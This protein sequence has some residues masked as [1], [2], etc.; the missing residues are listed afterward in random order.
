MSINEP[1][2]ELRPPLAGRNDNP[3]GHR[4]ECRRVM[5]GS[6]QTQRREVILKRGIRAQRHCAMGLACGHPPAPNSAVGALVD[7]FHVDC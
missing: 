3:L 2:G 1:G 7:F 5:D 4:A 6:R